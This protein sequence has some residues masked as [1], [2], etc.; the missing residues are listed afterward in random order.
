[1][2]L[3]PASVSP[4]A[5][6]RPVIAIVG[7]IAL[8]AALTLHRI[9]I[10]AAVDLS[11]AD[12]SPNGYTVCLLLFIVPIVVSGLWLVPKDDIKISKRS[13][14]GTISILFPLGAALDFFL[15]RTMAGG[16]FRRHR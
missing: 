5:S 2:P 10:S 1:M 12:P 7:M 6:F 13:L 15:A 3:R 16:A 11:I 9:Q 4:L 8:P 14:L